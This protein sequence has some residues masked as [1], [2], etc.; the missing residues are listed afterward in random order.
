MAAARRVVLGG[1]MTH[2]FTIGFAGA[3]VIGVLATAVALAAPGRGRPSPDIPSQPG[4]ASAQ[5]ASPG[6]D[7]QPTAS[8]TGSS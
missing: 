6:P 4:A 2:G 1:G 3:A 5:Q 8:R 7:R